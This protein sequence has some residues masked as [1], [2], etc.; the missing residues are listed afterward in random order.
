MPA[1]SIAT[2]VPVPIAM[3]TSACA[4]AGASLMPSPA[5]ATTRPSACSRRTT[6]RFCVRQHLARSP[7]R[8]RAS[9]ATA[10]AV[11][12]LS[13]VSITIAQARRRAAARIASGVDA[14]IGSATPT[15]PAS[16]AVDGDEHD[17]LPVA[18]SA[19][20]ALGERRRSSTPW[21][22]HQRGVAEQRPRGR[23]RRPRRPCPVTDSKLVGGGTATPA[24]RAPADDRRGQRMLAAL[25]ERRRPGAAR[26]A[27]VEPSAATIARARG[28]P[29]GQRAGLV[30]DQRVDLL[31][32]LER[33]GVPDQHAAVG[34]AAGADHDRHRRRQAERAGA[35]DDQH[36]HG[37]D[38][39]MRQPRL[40]PPDGSTRRTRAPRR[41]TTA[42]TNYAAT[43][44]AS[45]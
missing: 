11:A 21:S 39:R 20:A 18:R 6:S 17:R 4:S 32:P 34:A 40:G 41:R 1:L 29:F 43:R 23:R 31:E 37:A 2:S 5:M 42:G 28:L 25:L 14:L 30:D 27:S 13:P 19:S 35:G 24:L 15:S 16:V 3:P 33:L 7:R 22:L 44:S 10:L 8:C 12:A 26:R 36:R 38:Q 45:R 9:R